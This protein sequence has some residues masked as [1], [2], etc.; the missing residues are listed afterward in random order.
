VR[1]KGGDPLLFGRAAEE[2]AALRSA[3]IPYQIVPGIT[4]AFAAAAA[5]G[6][7]LTSRDSASSVLLTTGHLAARRTS[8]STPPTRVVYMPGTDWRAL[9]EELQHEGLS[10]QLPCVIVSHASCCDEKVVFSTI[11][12]LGLLAGIAAPSLLLVGE[13]VAELPSAETLV[14]PVELAEGA[15]KSLL[16]DK[17]KRGI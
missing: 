7:S 14:Q 3:G 16:F 8:P 4:S 5:A 11:D 6:C 15:S 10:P 2:M 17:Q 12:K 13:A 9:A 1:L